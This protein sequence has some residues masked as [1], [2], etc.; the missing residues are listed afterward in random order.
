MLFDNGAGEEALAYRKQYRGV[1]GITSN[2]ICFRSET[3]YEFIETALNL[4]P[5]LG[6]F[7]LEDIASPQIFTIADHLERGAN[8]P[9]F[10][11][12]QHGTA[13]VAAAVARSALE[14]KVARIEG[15][16]EIIAQR[17]R[18]FI[19]E[20]GIGVYRDEEFKLESGR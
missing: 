4:T 17:T 16:P 9:V 8:I 20:G 7:C 13:I 2:P 1:I 10:H 12:D 14:T 6:A 11:D 15:D 18:A 19:Y 5:T 3:P